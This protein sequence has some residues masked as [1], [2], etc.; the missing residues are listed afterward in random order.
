MTR[1]CRDGGRQILP[2]LY[3]ENARKDRIFRV[4]AQMFTLLCPNISNSQFLGG[5]RP[6]KPPVFYAY[7]KRKCRRESLNSEPLVFMIESVWK[8]S[9]FFEETIKNA[10]T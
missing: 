5:R 4:N 10:Q 1:I 3:V 7:A 6:Q 2:V 8:W 9:N